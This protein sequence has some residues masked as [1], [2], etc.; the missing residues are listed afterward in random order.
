[1]TNNRTDRIAVTKSVFEVIQC[2][3]LLVVA[4]PDW[5]IKHLS[6]NIFS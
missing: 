2:H 5:Q 3:V 1:M 4:V 6:L